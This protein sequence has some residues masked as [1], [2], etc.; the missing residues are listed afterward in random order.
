MTTKLLN[1]IETGHED[2]IHDAQVDYYGLRLATCSSDQS[3][4]VFNIKDD[5]HYLVAT[6]KGHLGPVWQLTWSHPKYGNLLASCSYD[7]KVIIWKEVGNDW[8][9]HY[10]YI[11]HASSV[12]SI[13][14]A[15]ESFGLIL[16][17]GSSD[18]S[19]SF[20]I[21]NR[22]TGNW[23]SKKIQNA[24]AIGVNAISWCPAYEKIS[25][26]D[27]KSN[28]AATSLEKRLVSGGCDNLV[29]IW[30]EIDNNWSEEIKLD[31]HSDWVR[32]VAWSPSLG[33]AD[34]LIASCSQDY[35]VIVWN[36]RDFINWTPTILNTFNDVVWNVSWSLTGDILSISYG[37]N[38][39]SLWRQNAQGKWINL[40]EIP[41]PLQKSTGSITQ[42]ID[43]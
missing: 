32:D 36:S 40:N 20:L 33:F 9:N 10:E 38:N 17:C 30:K 25:I 4:K 8:I 43:N 41:D 42:Q 2:M 16:A 14:W 31:I 23:T 18:G 21:S 3:V 28:S 1:K 5:N 29:K 7:K 12:N 35:R 39:V 19:I 37:H 34:S 11:N 15:P 27:Y 26:F 6:L 13:E 22:E 24:H